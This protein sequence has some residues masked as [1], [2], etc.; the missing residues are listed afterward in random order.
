MAGNE[1]VNE[2]KSGPTTSV[3]IRA[4]PVQFP[5]SAVTG[6]MKEDF[7]RDYRQH[8]KNVFPNKSSDVEALP[9]YTLDQR[10]RS[11]FA[12][13][14]RRK[15]REVLRGT[16][17]SLNAKQE[18]A[19]LA[20]EF[21]VENVT[22]GSIEIKTIIENLDQIIVAFGLT[23]DIVTTLLA[24]SGP[25]ALNAALGFSGVAWDVNVSAANIPAPGN[26]NNQEKG[27]GKYFTDPKVVWRVLNALWILPILVSLVVLVL[28]YREMVR[29]TELRDKV[30]SEAI[31]H[32]IGRANALYER[33]EKKHELLLESEANIF[34]RSADAIRTILEDQIKRTA[35][36]SDYF[37]QQH[38]ALLQRYE[39]ISK[40]SSDTIKTLIQQPDS[41]CD[42]NCKKPQDRCQKSANSK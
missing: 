4:E 34:R 1:P 17:P 32:E 36:R 22:Y 10:I 20:V 31:A 28:A 21:R 30:H 7:W 9:S 25:D 11:N 29:I 13:Q 18:S 38:V 5:R 27:I 19:L 33:F 15:F 12:D 2:S 14:L 35:A 3:T 23:A 42:C 24:A 16:R 26:G 6:D 37:D 39:N 40:E 8:I 41:C